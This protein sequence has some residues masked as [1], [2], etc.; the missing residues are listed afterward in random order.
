MK[1]WR[2]YCKKQKQLWV[3]HIA[4]TYTHTHTHTLTHTHY[5][6]NYW[7]A[8]GLICNIWYM[9]VAS[10]RRE[11]PIQ[12]FFYSVVIQDH[13]FATLL[14]WNWFM[15]VARKWCC[16][17]TLGLRFANINFL[18]LL[19]VFLASVILGSTMNNEITTGDNTLDS[20]IL[21]KTWMSSHAFQGIRMSTFTAL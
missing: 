6:K 14:G 21:M 13:I 3:V 11:M 17:G 18:T 12:E 4:Y 9:P 1:R 16:K 8:L 2:W 5:K 10:L 20:L 19:K 7:S 15:R